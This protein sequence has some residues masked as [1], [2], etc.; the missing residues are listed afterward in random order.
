MA[1]RANHV[2]K[3]GVYMQQCKSLTKIDLFFAFPLTDPLVPSELSPQSTTSL[4][5]TPD[6]V[7]RAMRD[8]DQQAAAGSKFCQTLS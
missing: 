1:G 8:N 7:L 5:W 4:Q 2:L 3:T 6:Q